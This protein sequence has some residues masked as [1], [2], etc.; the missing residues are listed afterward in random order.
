MTYSEKLKDPRW[1]RRR[2]EVLEAAGWKCSQCESTDQTLHVHHNFYRSRT[3]PWNYPDHAL[4]VVCEE[5]HDL[6]EEQRAEFKQLSE[7]LFE[8]AEGIGFA[9]ESVIG[10]MKAIRMFYALGTYPEHTETLAGYGQEYGFAR[11]WE[12]D[13]RDLAP[14]CPT[15]V[16][17][18]EIAESLWKAHAPRQAER[19]EAHKEVAHA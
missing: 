6:A 10:F 11:F 3:E 16:V 8:D 4:R 14:Q 1:Q 17:T 15:C 2:L 9:V 13:Q 19:L 18:G 7:A 5:C 12:G